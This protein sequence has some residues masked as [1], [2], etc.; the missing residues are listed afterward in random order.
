MK[1]MINPLSTMFHFYTL[2]TSENQRFFS[3]FR[4]FKSET[5]FEYGLR[6]NDA[7]IFNPLNASRWG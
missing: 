4:G 5:L 7:N 1:R 2:K 3:A 6:S